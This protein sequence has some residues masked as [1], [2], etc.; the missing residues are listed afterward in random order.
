MSDQSIALGLDTA[1]YSI[2]A[3]RRA[4]Y[5]FSDKAEFL[6]ETTSPQKINIKISVKESASPNIVQDFIN[7]VLDHQVRLDLEKEFGTLREII[8]A[9]AFAP[10]DD[11]SKILEYC[12]DKK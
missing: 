1:I 9:Q 3:I 11:L 5:D 10:R 6:I 4:V 7:C 12:H 8:V 2:Q